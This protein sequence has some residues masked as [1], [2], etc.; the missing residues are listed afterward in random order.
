M[1]K[2]ERNSGSFVEVAG[3]PSP[4]VSF[5]STTPPLERDSIESSTSSESPSCLERVASVFKFILDRLCALFCCGKNDDSEDQRTRVSE[6]FVP[7]PPQKD[8]SVHSESSSDSLGL[9]GPGR[10]LSLPPLSNKPPLS[11]PTPSRPATPLFP[12][13]DPFGSLNSWLNELGDSTPPPSQENPLPPSE[14]DLPADSSKKHNVP[15]NSVDNLFAWLDELEESYTKPKKKDQA[16][17]APERQ[18]RNF[19]SKKV[20][21]VPLGSVREK[22]VDALYLSVTKQDL[23]EQ[24]ARLTQDSKKIEEIV[25]RF[26]IFIW[27]A[28]TGKN[29]LR[30][31]IWEIFNY[32]LQ[33]EAEMGLEGLLGE[34]QDR[35]LAISEEERK[36]VFERIR[37]I[38]QGFVSRFLTEEE[39]GIFHRQFVLDQELEKNIFGLTTEEKR[40]I[41]ECIL[42]VSNQN[43]F[44]QFCCILKGILQRAH[45]KTEAEDSVDLH[46]CFSAGT[47]GIIER[48]LKRW[49]EDLK[50]EMPA[51]FGMNWMLG[52]EDREIKGH[53]INRIE[54]DI[55]NLWGALLEEADQEALGIKLSEINES[56]TQATDAKSISDAVR[57]ISRFMTVEIA[58]HVFQKKGGELNPNYFTACAEQYQAVL[59]SL[60]AWIFYSLPVEGAVEALRIVDEQAQK[61][62]NA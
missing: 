26:D 12:P 46:D 44:Q 59:S 9:G 54:G 55:R 58:D 21:E 11:G 3:S 62:Y 17:Q 16:A 8:P 19:A 52:K 40:A 14:V 57:S 7:P 24:V 45:V 42:K 1:S 2:V 32:L 23:R 22:E 15:V 43:S 25:G 39:Y 35:G 56:M 18:H 4:S 20:S 41:W 60:T 50:V 6:P 34:G 47:S 13:K 28:E 49:A 10:P 61:Q 38:L 29:G 37:V 36:E 30:L 48:L 27:A 53:Y 31:G 5:K 33:Q 51:D